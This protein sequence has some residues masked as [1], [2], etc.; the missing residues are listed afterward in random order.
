MQKEAWT[1]SL[2]GAALGAFALLLRWLQREMI[3]DETGLPLSRAPISILLVVFLFAA[4]AALWVLSGRLGGDR[5]PEEPEDALAVHG[6]IPTVFLALAGAAAL[7]GALLTV[8]QADSLF[9]RV[10]ALT[11]VFAAAVLILYPSLPRWG[12]FG[13]GLSLVPVVF[14]SLWLVVSYKD[15][16][17]DPVV[18][19]YGM[20]ILA[21]SAALYA[22]YRLC[23]Y[24][25][26]RIRSR[27]AVF[28]CAA[29]TV[30]CLSVL[31][32]DLAFGIRILLAGWAV[33]YTTI[34]WILWR[35]MLP[36]KAPEA[37][38]ADKP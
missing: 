12:E 36:E 16:A 38:T 10:S 25:Y 31:M 21:V 27:R 3:I 33:G 4:A 23:G 17:V 7:G 13:A 5:S 32:D 20:L 26:Y 11:G 14:F 15:N 35:N 34:G 6:F 29:A 2:T 22:A 19:D 9:L 1:Y 28:A 30:L 18:W 24:V 37:E 8:V